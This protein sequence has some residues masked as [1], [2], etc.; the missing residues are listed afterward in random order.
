MQPGHQFSDDVVLQPEQRS[1]DVL[2][3]KVRIDDTHLQLLQH[4]HEQQPPEFEEGQQAI[5][6]YV[7]LF[8]VNCMTFYCHSKSTWACCFAGF[9]EDHVLSMEAEQMLDDVHPDQQLQ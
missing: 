4:L 7:C 3:L 1:S 5:Q 8:A 6:S 2:A 9:T